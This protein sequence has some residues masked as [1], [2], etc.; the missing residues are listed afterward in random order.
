L[1]DYLQSPHLLSVGTVQGVGTLGFGEL[2]GGREIARMLGDLLFGRWRGTGRHVSV[3]WVV[4]RQSPGDAPI[5]TRN[6]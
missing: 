5:R 1:V 4:Q 6:E 2:T 3:V